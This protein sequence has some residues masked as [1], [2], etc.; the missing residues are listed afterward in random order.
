MREI[1]G[2]PRQDR[3]P[4]PQFA[5]ESARLVFDA[6]ESFPED[7]ARL[8]PRRGHRKTEVA[9]EPPSERYL[10]WT[11]GQLP[12]AC[13]ARQFGLESQRLVQTPDSLPPASFVP[14]DP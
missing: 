9:S 13:E 5:R 14:R 10:R 4:P 3:P 7:L 1:L 2:Q 8:R 12:C 11:L 6:T